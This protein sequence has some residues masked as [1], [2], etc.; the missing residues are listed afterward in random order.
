MF[1][2]KPRAFATNSLALFIARHAIEREYDAAVPEQWR[3]FFYMP[4]MHSETTADQEHCVALFS[5]LPGDRVKYAIEHRD[6][7][8]RFGRFPHR[9]KVLGRKTTAAEQ[10]FLSR[11]QGLWPVGP[12]RRP[13][14]PARAGLHQRL[15]MTVD[16]GT[17]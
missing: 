8:A 17:I 11:A 7:I 15:I 14:C 6:I 3:H 4:F 10:A 2:G 1:R 5:A 13:A 16:S 9:N 12:A